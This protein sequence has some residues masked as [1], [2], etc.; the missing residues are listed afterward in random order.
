MFLGAAVHAL[1]DSIML[2]EEKLRSGRVRFESKSKLHAH[3]LCHFLI[4]SNF[5]ASH[6][7]VT[8]L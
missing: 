1:Y 6:L 3:R 5:K 4:N 2:R 8:K 7:K